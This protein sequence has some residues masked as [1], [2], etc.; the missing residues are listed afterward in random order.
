MPRSHV[1]HCRSLSRSLIF[2]SMLSACSAAG[3]PAATS[4]TTHDVRYVAR[5]VSLTQGDGGG[6]GADRLPAIVEGPPHGAGCCAGSTDVVSLGNGGEIV[7]AFDVDVV[8][9]PGVDL[10]VFENPFEIAGDPTN[11][12]SELGEVSVSEDGV[13]WTTFPCAQPTP[14]NAPPPYGQCAGWR[15]VMATVERPVDARDAAKAGGDAYD[16]ATIGVRRARY[17]RVRDLRSERPAKDG[18]AGF[19]L[20][21]MAAVHWE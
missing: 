4:D 6:Y 21:A 17:V 14:R 11:L 2:A 13:A 10:I 1:S 8:D 7:V 9:E 15:P 20:D 5:L 12:W 3:E 18:T 19:D 16:L